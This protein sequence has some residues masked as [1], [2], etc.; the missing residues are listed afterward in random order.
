MEEKRTLKGKP[1]H[2]IRSLL[3]S[4]IWDLQCR[5]SQC[6]FPSAISSIIDFYICCIS[7][8]HRQQNGYGSKDYLK[9]K[10]I[11][12]CYPLHIFQTQFNGHFLKI[13]M[14]STQPI[15]QCMCTLVSNERRNSHLLA[16]TYLQ[17]DIVGD[18]YLSTPVTQINQ[19]IK[20]MRN[21][22]NFN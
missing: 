18:P 16:R 10:S 17:S 19:G 20:T 4:L 5:L 7:Q 8:I 2:R 3:A 13:L 6:F 9:V 14:L 11:M 15:S 1:G 22:R 21:R 12:Q